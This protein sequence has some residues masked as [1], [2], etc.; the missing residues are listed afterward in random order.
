MQL[1]VQQ[2]C[3]PVATHG[4][5]VLCQA[6]SGMGKTAV[7]VLS[8]L[9]QIEPADGLVSVL[10]LCHTRELAIQIKNVF[11]RFSRCLPNIKTQAFFGGTPIDR[12]IE[13]LRD[14]MTCP[15]IVVGTVGRTLYLVRKQ[16]LKLR[17]L[18][19]LVIDECDHMFIHP[20]SRRDIQEIYFAAPKEKQVMMFSATLPVDLRDE[21]KKLMHNP[22]EIYADD[23][24]LTLDGLQQF[25]VEV[26][27]QEKIRVLFELMDNISFNQICIFVKTVDRAQ[28]L[29][30]LM[31]LCNFPSICIHSQLAQGE[32]VARYQAFKNFEK[33]I[34]VATDL[35]GRGIDIERVNV[36]VN[37]DMAE[38]PAQYLHR[39]GRAGRFGTKG[40]CISFLA[41]RMDT[42]LMEKVKTRFQVDAQLL[43]QDTD[44]NSY[45]A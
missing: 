1:I 8:T 31:V 37:F 35:F 42:Q 13:I 29:D 41:D 3:I 12:D 6:K 5:D 14:R 19:H 2:A 24:V 23:Q 34:M 40:A 15:H 39:A 20:D 30:R 36:V 25:Y 26:S 18:K 27:E 17:E 32:R 33:R 16:H 21:C 38:T 7:Y 22:L 43:K 11:D 45:L 9:Q 44:I 28:Y 4:V 10:V